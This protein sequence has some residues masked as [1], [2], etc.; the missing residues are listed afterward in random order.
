M[1]K[2]FEFLM[3]KVA[4]EEISVNAIVKDES[5]WVKDSIL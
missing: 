2:Q 4:D 5:I 3:Y 1:E